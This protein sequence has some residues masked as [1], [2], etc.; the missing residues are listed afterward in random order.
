MGRA[1]DHSSLKGVT[2]GK[3]QSYSRV[4][5]DRENLFYKVL[6]VVPHFFICVYALIQVRAILH[7]IHVD[8]PGSTTTTLHSNPSF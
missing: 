2:G 3:L 7:I 5:S 8:I 4:L 6:V 1:A